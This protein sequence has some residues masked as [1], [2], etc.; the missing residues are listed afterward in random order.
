[1]EFDHAT[2]C[3]NLKEL[4]ERKGYNKYEMSIQADIHYSYYLAIENGKMVPNF[5]GLIS[6]ANALNTDISHLLGRKP[7]HKKDIVKKEILSKL[8]KVQNNELL[9][10]LYSILISIRLWSEGEPENERL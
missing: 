3:K 2:F 1:M 10:S 9:D 8:L 5:R 4:R 6:I 7:L